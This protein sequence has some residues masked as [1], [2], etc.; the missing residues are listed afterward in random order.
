MNISDKIFEKALSLNPLS[1]EELLQL[2][3]LTPTCDLMF[4]ANQLRQIHVPGNG[5]SWQIDRNVNII[6]F[7]GDRMTTGLNI[8]V[9]GRETAHSHIG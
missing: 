2:Y 8:A 5:V 3:K 4:I 1:R 7:M 9:Q 6:K